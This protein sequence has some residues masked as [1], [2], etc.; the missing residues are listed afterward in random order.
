MVYTDPGLSESAEVVAA[1]SQQGPWSLKYAMIAGANALVPVQREI[2]D[3]LVH[4]RGR[5][6]HVHGSVKFKA[7]A[8][9]LHRGMVG[10]AIRDPERGVDA[11]KWFCLI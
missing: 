10:T 1:I 3:N 7:V 2:V 9:R 6:I 8:C 11:K 4:T 5:I